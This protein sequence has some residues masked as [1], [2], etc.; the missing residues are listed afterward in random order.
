MV[1]AG[2]L[3]A[4]YWLINWALERKRFAKVPLGQI[5]WNVFA[6]AVGLLFLAPLFYI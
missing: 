3:T 1:A 2:I 5:L 4:G 6:L